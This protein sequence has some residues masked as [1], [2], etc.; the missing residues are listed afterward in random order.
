MELLEKSILNLNLINYPNNLEIR[1][2]CEEEYL[3]SALIYMLM[4]IFDRDKNMENTVCLHILCAL[5]NLMKRSMSKK[6][7]EGSKEEVMKIL[8]QL[9]DSTIIFE[10]NQLDEKTEF[11]PDKQ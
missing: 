7:M 6:Q 1:H 2:I 10:A 8:T 4:T 9:K 3:S 11:L 5:Y